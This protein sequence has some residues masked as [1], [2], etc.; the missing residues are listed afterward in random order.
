[1]FLLFSACASGPRLEAMIADVAINAVIAEASPLWKSTQIGEITGSV[2]TNRLWKAKVSKQVFAKVLRQSL[3]LHAILSD[4]GARFKISAKL[5]ELKQ[6]LLGLELSVTAR[7][8][9]KI[10]V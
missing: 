1:M 9:Y 5:K 10:T 4:G 2:K 3:G 6:P 8:D 7:V